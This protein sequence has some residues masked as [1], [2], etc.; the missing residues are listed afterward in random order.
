MG[1]TYTDLLAVAGSVWND[2]VNINANPRLVF[3]RAQGVDMSS[4]AN[5]L[6]T[7]YPFM[8]RTSMSTFSIGSNNG[9][10][11][12][13]AT[14]LDGQSRPIDAKLTGSGFS[15]L[16]TG[17]NTVNV[18]RVDFSYP[19]G[20]FLFNIATTTGTVVANVGT[21][22]LS[23][24]F[25]TFSFS[26]PW[27]T[28]NATG[29]IAVTGKS[30]SLADFSTYLKLDGQVTSL[31]YTDMVNGSTMQLQGALHYA[32]DGLGLVTYDGTITKATW[33][34]FGGLASN[35][36][37]Y[38]GSFTYSGGGIDQLGTLSGTVSSA[39]IKVGNSVIA[40]TG[41][42]TVTNGAL[43]GTVTGLTLTA[44]SG[45]VYS[46]SGLQLDALSLFNTDGSVRDVNCNGAIDGQ[47][48]LR[49]FD[50]APPVVTGITDSTSTALTNAAVTFLVTFGE[51]L[52]GTPGLNNF[53]ALHG[54][55]TAV[56]RISDTVVKVVVQPDNGVQGVGVSLMLHGN[57]LTDA[58]GNMVVDANLAG[59][60]TQQIDTLAPVAPSGLADAAIS[61]NG[62]VNSTTQVIA[63]TAEPDVQVM[64]YDAD[65]RLLGSGMSDPTTGAFS[66]TVTALRE[67]AHIVK[68]M[69]QDKG[70]NVSPLSSGLSFSV[71][72]MPP[73]IVRFLPSNGQK[74][75]AVNSALLFQFN[76]SIHAGSGSVVIH[77]GSSTGPVVDTFALSGDPGFS[78]AGNTLT[79]VPHQQLN[80]GELYYVTFAGSVIE[81]VALNHY[82]PATLF[83]FTTNYDPAGNI[84]ISGSAQQHQLLTAVTAGLGD[85]DG[86][87]LLSYQ[88]QADGSDIAGAEGM[89]YRI[90][91]AD[92]GKV[93]SLVVR[94]VDGAGTMEQLVSQPT[95]PVAEVSSGVVIDGYLANALVW[96]DTDTAT[97]GFN[98]NDAGVM[99]G[100]WDPGEGDAW[101]LTDASG[102]FTGLSGTGIMHMQD[103][104]AVNS[105]IS[106]TVDISTGSLFSGS[107]S[108][109]SGSLVVN[110]LTT[111]IT[112]GGVS[113][114]ALK[115]M[116]GLDA[117]IDLTAYDPLVEAS[118]SG[119]TPAAVATAINVQSA[120]VQI[121]NIMA[122]ATETIKAAGGTTSNVVASVAQSLMA[123]SVGGVLDLASATVIEGAINSAARTAPNMTLAANVATSAAAIAASAALVNGSV[124][125]VAVTATS[126]AQGNILPDPLVDMKTIASAQI[127]AQQTVGQDAAQ[128]VA[129]NSAASLRIT[130]QATLGSEMLGASSMVQTVFVNHALTGALDITGEARLGSTLMVVPRL[131]D[132]EGLP[133]S[134]V[135]EWLADGVVIAGVTGSS[136][137]LTES[138]IGKTITVRTAFV[139][140]GGYAES[141]SSEPTGTV[142]KV[143][144]SLADVVVHLI[145]ESD[146]GIASND[147]LTNETLPKVSVDL[148]GKQLQVGDVIEILDSNHGNAVTGLYT[149]SAADLAAGV[150]VVVISLQ[151]ALDDAPHDLMVRLTD[152]F[153]NS[154]VSSQVPLRVIIDTTQPETTL[155]SIMLSM[156]TGESAI[157][158]VTSAM[159]QT[160]TARL[161]QELLLD[162]HLYGSVDGGATWSDITGH[163]QGLQL[164]WSTELLSG[165]HQIAL[166]IRDAAGN[167]GLVLNSSYELDTVLPPGVTGFLDPLAGTLSGE[168]DAPLSS[169]EALFVSLD[170]GN[171]WTDISGTV[172]ADGRLFVWRGA[173]GVTAAMLEV[174]DRAAN[175]VETTLSVKE[176]TAVVASEDL[177]LVT[178]SFNEQVIGVHLPAGMTITEHADSGSTANSWFRQMQA[179]VDLL[180]AG[181]EQMSTRLE[182]F[183]SNF[184]LTDQVTVRSLTLTGNPVATGEIVSFD[185]PVETT[186]KELLVL[187]LPA[188]SAINLNNVDF[189]FLSGDDLTVRGGAGDNILFAGDG[190][191]NIVLGVGDDEL[192]GGAG[193]DYIGSLEGN[194]T[195]YG[196]GG[197]DTISGGADNDLLYGGSGDDLLDGGSGVDTAV[198]DGN[199]SDF[200][201]TYNPITSLFDVVDTRVDH[202]GHDIL[203]NI[204]FL[205]FNDVTK[206]VTDFA[207]AYYLPPHDTTVESVICAGIGGI[208]L[209]ALL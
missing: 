82:T 182:A 112:E 202:E 153:G 80:P 86:L 151:Q 52:I 29:A 193:D 108:A 159:E 149:L 33:S 83:H 101:V 179:A 120:A 207:D 30:N 134:F 2:S 190:R 84:S 189:V 118:K 154:G 203:S 185:A 13:S 161:S 208:L 107:Y 56:S 9:V 17:S 129:S 26:T 152:S 127:V 22:T 171:S 144:S 173:A 178:G 50:P 18:S 136:L 87:G 195:L 53:S 66:V 124:R 7:V 43:S 55:V 35:S 133:A 177:A 109:P 6:S 172:D 142:L 130:D 119:A 104:A 198:F 106:T 12:F 103:N 205:Q 41:A 123:A 156:D 146:H 126:L 132:A 141:I 23:G 95:L 90:M 140:G 128:A 180:H 183:V 131:S 81:D 32:Q 170:E 158:G 111:C 40:Y 8:T 36:I 27:V 20:G 92:V 31:Q 194:D 54:A 76:E 19:A 160:V 68:A 11:I 74:G 99:N 209:W 16:F 65:M 96:I 187:D 116:L 122:V 60:D 5:L 46:A 77:S 137:T 39:Q 191:Q 25:G 14:F 204:E 94:Y 201:I 174:R 121:T 181:S 147:N 78:I 162:E 199:I 51:A 64:L 1:S 98:W 97:P 113:E 3:E 4:V 102:Q 139:D 89:T 148:T 192:H 114:A 166:E 59:F 73:G 75:V 49:V 15:N 175:R 34:G 105:R 100:Q 85:A 117:A 135:Y 186:Y 164:E 197:N 61:V 138:E 150:G 48:L 58:A 91:P 47:D 184:A 188:G 70:G 176:H 67:G 42:L 45:L 10:G 69:A 163:V 155:S 143:P 37:S 206:P 168:L 72:S 62:Y 57:G 88:W 21:G 157:D 79:L 93:I 63:G 28:I 196:E 165:V 167:S 24:N 145:G 200:H 115:T 44:P 169:G 125:T 110:A 38:T 71:D